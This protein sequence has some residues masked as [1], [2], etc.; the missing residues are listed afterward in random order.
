[1]QERGDL[2]LEVADLGGERQGQAGLDGDVFGQLGVVDLLVPEGECLLSR[3]QQ[4]GGVVL[5]PGARE[6]NAR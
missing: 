2:L 4:P 6:S 1:V 3:A 5:A